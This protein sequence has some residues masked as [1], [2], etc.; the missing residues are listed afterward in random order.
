MT[1]TWSAVYVYLHRSRADIDT[2]L[3]D[4]LAPEAE[5]LVSSGRAAAWFFLRYWDGGPHLRVRFL[6]ADP[7]AVAEF[8]ERVRALAKET[9][10]AALDLDSE[11]YYA[12]LPQADPARWYAD[13]DVTEAVY[14]PETERYGGPRALEACEDFFVVSTRIALAV[15][16]SAP[17][18]H[19]RQ[20][21]AV[22]LTSLAFGVLGFD[23]V[24]AVR[25]ARGYYATWDY[26]AEVARG[27]TQARAEA[28]RLFHSAPARWLQRRPQVAR[29]VSGDGASTHHLWNRG[30]RE[31]VARLRRIDAEEGLANGLD[32]IVWSLLHMTHNR[33]GLDIDDER[34]IAWLL[35]LAY[36]RWEPPGDY[37]D[38]GVGSP[39]RTYLEASKYLPDTMAGDHLPREVPPE[40]V[41]EGASLAPTVPLPAPA[42][43]SASLGRVLAERNS[44]HGDY[45]SHLE[46]AALSALL[47]HGAGI[48]RVRADQPGRHAPPRTHPSPG[49]AYATEVWVVARHVADL[50]PG[51]YRYQPEGHRLLRADGVPET[52]RLTELSPFLREHA[53]GRPGVE[54]STTGALVFLVGDLGRLREGYGQRALRLLLQECGHVAQNLSLCAAALGLRS[55]VVSGFADDAANALLHLDGVDRT[56]LTLLPVGT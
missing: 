40:G 34:R 11:A 24:T 30:L 48:S 54:A 8:A 55:L 6:D 18:Q 1:R 5:R 36:P 49:A 43:L 53:D 9:S 3:L 23:D 41:R 46:L 32:R 17:H 45:G 27:G 19:Q 15:L 2:F 42:P 44:D 28:E 22:D 51:V 16:R 31:T 39:D 10:A 26:S 7:D 12:D 33:L 13:G 47:G 20:V 35:S 50:E 37:F 29:L 38:P 21:V 4:H 25:Q 56:V 52:D 14:E